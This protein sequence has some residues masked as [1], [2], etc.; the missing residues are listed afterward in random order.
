[1]TSREDQIDFAGTSKAVQSFKNL[2]PIP[3]MKRPVSKVKRR[4]G[5]S[6]C[7][8]S[9][10]YK[11]QLMETVSLSTSKCKA[12]KRAR[13]E[14]TASLQKKKSVKVIEESTACE[15]NNDNTPCL[16]CEIPYCISRVQWFMC[17]KCL[18]WMCVNCARVAKKK[19]KF[20]CQNCSV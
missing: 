14:K 2:A 4:V 10:P 5:H 13:S 7:L 12:A 18:K 6:E 3:H 17:A 8:S 9:S 11:L 16:F 20:V 15:S 1:M 19:S